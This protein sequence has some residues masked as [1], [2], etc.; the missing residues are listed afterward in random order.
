MADQRQKDDVY[1]FEG[2]L[3]SS[4]DQIRRSKVIDE[5]TKEK[6]RAFMDHIQ[7]Q[8]AGEGR[9]AK[10]AYHLLEVC[11]RLKKPVETVSMQD[12]ERLMNSLREG[13]IPRKNQETR[14]E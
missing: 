6:I 13:Y 7:A 12:V 11:E 1:D 8:G 5:A 3:R 4:L 10:Y 2:E 14:E 9:R